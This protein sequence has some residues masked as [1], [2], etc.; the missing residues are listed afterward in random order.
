M[1]ESI[2]PDTRYTNYDGKRLAV[3]FDGKIFKAYEVG[4]EKNNLDV[5]KDVVY[6]A[7]PELSR[8]TTHTELYRAGYYT[9]GG[10]D[11]K[12]LGCWTLDEDVALKDDEP[13][14]KT[15]GTIDPAHHIGRGN[16]DQYVLQELVR[17]GDRHVKDQIEAILGE[18]KIATHSDL[19]QDCDKPLSPTQ[20]LVAHEN[21]I[22]DR[23]IPNKIEEIR[24]ALRQVSDEICNCSWNPDSHAD[25][26]PV[27]ILERAIYK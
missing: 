24:A 25:T 27:G 3:E 23:T 6:D 8:G 1:S 12:H 22:V 26:C 7:Y 9:R 14:T 16:V 5:T 20:L 15:I 2:T 11:Q 18:P 19:I 21:D 10:S 4:S 13:Q 17:N